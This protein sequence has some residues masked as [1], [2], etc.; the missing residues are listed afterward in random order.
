MA[1][2]KVWVKSDIENLGLQPGDI[3]YLSKYGIESG[4]YGCIEVFPD[5]ELNKGIVLAFDSDVPIVCSEKG[6]GVFSFEENVDRFV[7][8]SVEKFYLTIKRFKLYCEQ[9]EDI[10]DENEALKVVNSAI[11]DMKEINET[12]WLSANNY[13]PIIGQQMEEGNL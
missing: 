8:S 6:D 10:E 9:V 7:N 3:E 11:D 1:N 4:N 5:F 13:W 2:T 12:A